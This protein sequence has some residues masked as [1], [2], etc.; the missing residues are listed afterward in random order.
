[1]VELIITEKPQAALKIATALAD[2]KPVKRQVGQVAY[3]EVTHGK[4]DLLIGCA[5]GHLF[6]IA[7]KEKGKWVY[8]MFDVTWMPAADVR[9]DSAFT[10]K[11]AD[12]LKT[13]AKKASSFTVATDYD[14]EGEV[15]GANVVRYLCKQKDAARMKF[16][17]LTKPD[18]VKAYESK[19]KTLNWG[20]ALAG[21]TRHYLDWY[22]GINY[23]RALTAAIKAA[24]TFKI[25]STGRVQGPALKI[26]V[27]REREITAFRS[28]PYWEIQLDGTAKGEAITAFHQLGKFLEK[29]AAEAVMAKVKDQKK[30]AIASAEKTRFKQKPPVPFDLTTLQTEAYRCLNLAPKD[31]LALAQELYIGGFISYPRTS[32]QK[33]PKEIGYQG[34][35]SQLAKQET[36]KDLI[37]QL[38]K[39]PL[40]PQEGTK[41]DPAHPSIYPTGVA[42]SLEGKKERLY[43][44]VVRRFLAV[45]GE[46]A[47]REKVV[48]HIEVN[49]ERFVTQGVTTVEKGW[50]YYYGPFATLKEELLPDLKQGDAFDVQKI[51][52]LSK[53][54]QPPKRYTPASIIKELERRNLGTKATRSEIV[55]TLFR[56][57]YVN[58]TSIQA[59]EI[60]IKTMETLEKYAP[61][62]VDEELT[63]HFEL[64]IEEIQEGKKKE[65][66]VLSEAKELLTKILKEF[67]AKE[68][69]IGEELAVAERETI[70]E[71]TTVGKCPKCSEGTLMIR[72]GKFG[73]FIACDKYPECKTTFKLPTGS[74]AK[75]SEKLCEHCQYPMM[76]MI[77]KAKKPQELCINQD[78]PSKKI[79]ES[80][81]QEKPCPKCKEGKMVLRKSMYGAF[82]GCNRYPKCRNIERLQNNNNNANKEN[83]TPQPNKK[84]DADE[85]KAPP[86]KPKKRKSKAV[87]K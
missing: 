38:L 20:L 78:C 73:R 42:P 80:L 5:V 64:E 84:S 11:Y 51:D 28:T 83:A 17:T 12:V 61:K 85:T 70:N 41:T 18:L 69:Q 4:N 34:I 8:P 10:A 39:K 67:K 52:L 23:S 58:G 15:I 62:I 43:D 27:D 76:L 87:K 16:S 49:K 21:E 56:R 57:G 1:M 9:K 6:T 53:E 29:P 68:K 19:A 82:M 47:L 31:T 24:G 30:G 71:Q 66:Q 25:M 40:V 46:D 32:S 54:T 48:I 22:N 72:R 44:L 14:I 77:R 81:V 60:G 13:L 45:F 65:E 7:E 50:Q 33:L 79:D 36:Y 75:V 59:T 2:G 63:R 26:V 35:M 74:I 55:E 37:T 3:Y 86:A